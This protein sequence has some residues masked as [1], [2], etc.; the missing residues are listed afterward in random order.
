MAL[1][2]TYLIFVGHLDSNSWSV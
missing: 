2:L 1:S